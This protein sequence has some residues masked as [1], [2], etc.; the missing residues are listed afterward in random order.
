MSAAQKHYQAIVRIFESNADAKRAEGAKAYM[1]NQFEFYGLTAPDRK[2]LVR[3]YWNSDN[4]LSIEDLPEFIELCWQHPMR[5]LQYVG[6]DTMIQLSKKL[7]RKDIAMLELMITERSWWDTVDL[8][9]SRGAGVYFQ[10]FP[11]EI[12]L[13]IESWMQ[14]DNLWLMRS[15]LLF[16]L[17]YKHQTNVQLLE[18][19]IVRLQYHP[20]FF[21]RKAIG[22]VL[23]QYARTDARFVKNFVQTHELSALSKKEA[24]KNL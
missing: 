4:R 7:Q 1:R 16:Q 6:M 24:L 2:A 23:R 11:E 22:W 19:L 8:V 9:A 5:E 13:R 3:D 17:N 10:K 18:S 14:S 20:D 15:A 12:P 21:I